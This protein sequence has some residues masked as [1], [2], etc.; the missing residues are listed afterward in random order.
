M[1]I[2]DLDNLTGEESPE[3]LEEL[4]ANLE[5]DDLQ[6]VDDKSEID[7]ENNPAVQQVETKTDENPAVDNPEGS[8]SSD[9]EGSAED[10]GK[11][12]EPVILAKDGE[13]TIPFDVLEREREANK[14]LQK[15]LEELKAQQSEYEQD[16]RLLEIRNKQLEGMGVEPKDLPENLKLTEEQLESL[17][18]DYPD[19]G[20]VI[21]Y[22][23][24]K[25]DKFES[26]GVKQPEVQQEPS[27]PVGDAIAENSD[28][29][30]WQK[31]G[32]EQWEKALQVDDQL[33]KDPEWRNKPLTERFAKVVEVVKGQSALASDDKAKSVQSKAKQEEE[34]LEDSLP[35]SPSEVGQT[36]GHQKTR[37]EIIA[38]GNAGEI[39]SLFS[40][41]SDD[42]V[43]AAL[44][45]LGI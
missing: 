4:L 11:P 25:V 34:K 9:G 10:E 29:S 43:E 39:E 28:L 42:Q 7:P 22:L 26:A 32:G 40:G 35:V 13:N 36:A 23:S 14:E 33:M 16:K 45:E 27:N 30:A 31:A 3:E 2:E 20:Q 21:R 5:G 41:M 6:V 1:G 15:Q 17:A 12:S 8:A 44:A 19:I 37:E 18:E 38:S 24:A